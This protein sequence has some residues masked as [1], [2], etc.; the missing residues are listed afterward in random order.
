MLGG[1]LLFEIYLSQPFF[2]V[3]LH[4]IECNRLQTKTSSG[5]MNQVRNIDINLKYYIII[6]LLC[7]FYY[8]IYYNSVEKQ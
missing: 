2:I 7:I 4:I 8:I 1:V 5:M 3:K 6:I